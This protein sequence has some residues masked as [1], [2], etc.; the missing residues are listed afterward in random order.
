MLVGEIGTF[1]GQQGIEAVGG[2][3]HDGIVLFQQGGDSWKK[4]NETLKPTLIKNQCQGPVP[5][6]GELTDKDG[7]W[8]AHSWIDKYGGRVFTTAVGA[9]C[10]EVYYRYLPMYSK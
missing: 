5:L 6:N 7:S 9:L 3:A 8:E 2:V 1:A 4:W 10:M